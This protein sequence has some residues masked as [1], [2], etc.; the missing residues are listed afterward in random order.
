MSLR[1][2]NQHRPATDQLTQDFNAMIEQH[3][4]AFDV[5]VF[6]V[7]GE[8]E[9]VTA[10]A[11]QDVVGSLE[12]DERQLSYGEPFVT[13]AL[14]P[15]HSIE[16]HSMLSS[17]MGYGVE[18]EG[19]TPWRLLI[20]QGPVPKRS[21]VA[22]VTDTGQGLALQTL[23]VMGANSIGRRAP[24]GY[25]YELIPYLG[26][27]QPLSALP[28]AD[29]SVSDIIAQLDT[30]LSF[31]GKATSMEPPMPSDEDSKIA[32]LREDI[33]GL[34]YTYQSTEPL[35]THVVEHGLDSQ[36]VQTDVWVMDSDGKYYR[37]VVNVQET[38]P[39]R[40]T[41][42]VPA[43]ANIKVIVKKGEAF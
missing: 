39:K 37:D 7:G 42:T 4:M 34:R 8:K 17:G 16:M 40:L 3:P 22:Y 11:M 33:D 25:V 15:Q 26:G 10:P 32:A 35:E 2:V 12:S 20:R 27:M 23:Y 30:L 31:D 1:P 28:D 5:I 6:P 29:P 9:D 41:V 14:E 43:P 13:L 19:G 21:V 36:F 24:A 38:S 18:Q